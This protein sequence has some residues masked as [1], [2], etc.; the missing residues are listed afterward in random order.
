MSIVQVNQVSMEFAGNYVL[1]DIT[2]SI[3]H[4]SRIGLIGANGSGKSTL[5]RIILGHLQASSGTVQKAKKCRVAYLAQNLLLDKDMV[6]IEYIRNSRSD[7]RQLWDEIE[8]LSH[9]IGTHPE[10]DKEAKLNT[11]INRYQSLGGFE[12]DNELKYILKLLNFPEDIWH[13]SLGEFS[14]GEQ[15]RICL[16]S[17]LLQENDLLIMD[18][19]T[20]HLDIAM[21]N[22]LEKYLTKQDRPY[23]IVSHDRAFLDNVVSSIYYLE[24]GRLSITKGNYSSFKAARDIA[25]MS[26]ERMFERQQKWIKETEDFVRRNIAGQK[27][28]QAKSRLKQLQKVEIINKPKAHKQM[29]LSIHSAGRSGNDVF[30]MEEASIGIAGKSLA[31]EIDLFAH[32]R[33][34]ICILG[35]NGCGKTTLIKTLLGENPLLDGNLKVG[36]SL[37]IGYYDQHHIALDEDI[38]V[39]ETLWQIIPD[40]TNG[41]V[42]SWLARFGFR[43]DDVEK[44]VGILSGGEKS[45]LYLCILIHQNPNLLIMD[46]PTNHLDIDM[47]D[48]LLEAL[49]SFG[50]TIIFVSHDRYFVKEL[51]TRYW[52][53]CQKLRG[54]ELYT[55]VQEY[56]G[57]VEGAL[58][59]AFEIPE[60]PKAEPILRERKKKINP[61]HLEQAQKA[62][63]A[64]YKQLTESTQKVDEIHH[65]LADSKTYEDSAK[66][67]E[68]NRQLA[69]IETLILAQ[70]IEIQELEEKYLEL[71]YE[72]S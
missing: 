1:Q 45:R 39:K 10:P 65:L 34:R 66:V 46:E 2:C 58:T 43:G 22:W 62:I 25:L 54:R 61:W 21:I 63:D 3:E 44:S 57:D 42:L 35:P 5:I 27:T 67:L 60:P 6:M 12:F 40:A 72:D 56:T 24:E 59:K 41:Y 17:I 30:V 31:V 69:E 49:R 53:F 28:I 20:N 68:L 7:L 9:A 23:L 18:E 64:A 19:P 37:D 26:Q 33:D 50:G 55:T 14:G 15:T 38:S 70:N 11:M 8:K 32:Y 48:A 71:S 4:N 13:K 47:A 51:S 29:N 16:A 52:V 36:A